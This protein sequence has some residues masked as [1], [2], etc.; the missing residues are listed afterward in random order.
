MSQRRLPALLL[1]CGSTYIVG[2]Q[3]SC[4]LWIV[5]VLLSSVLGSGPACRRFVR[6]ASRRRIRGCPNIWTQYMDAVV[7]CIVAARNIVRPSAHR[8]CATL[9]VCVHRADGSGSPQGTAH[10]L[11]HNGRER[12]ETGLGGC[13]SSWVRGGSRCVQRSC[14]PRSRWHE[15]ARRRSWAMMMRTRRDASGEERKRR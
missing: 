4:A 14:P 2:V 7:P 10:A 5:G 9:E 3:S 8:R 1:R 13:T 6:R 15:M 11:V 12:M